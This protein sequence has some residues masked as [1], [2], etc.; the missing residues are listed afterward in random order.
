M[1]HPLVSEDR[2]RIGSDGSADDWASIRQAAS[3]VR[4]AAIDYLTGVREQDLDHEIPYVGSMQSLSGRSISLRYAISRIVAH[5]YFHVG[6][7]ASDLVAA[8]LDV[9]DYPGVMAEALVT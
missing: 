7:M 3:E 8:G 2:W 4:T 1:P 6:A 9:G 5:T